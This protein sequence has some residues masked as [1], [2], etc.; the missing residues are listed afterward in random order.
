MN[1]IPHEP[2]KEQIDG[3][4]FE[5]LQL[6]HHIFQQRRKELKLTQQQVADQARIQLR[7]YQRLESGEQSV[8]GSSSRIFFSV[9]QVLRLEPEY[10]LGLNTMQNVPDFQRKKCVILDPV[11]DDGIYYYIPQSAYF[12]LVCEIP[13][14]MIATYDAIKECLRKAYNLSNGEI[15]N[16]MDS[17]RLHDKKYFPYWRVVSSTGHLM[18]MVYS[19]KESQKEFLSKE[20]LD[21]KEDT[22]TNSYSVVNYKKHLFSFDTLNISVRRSL[23]QILKNMEKIQK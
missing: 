12:Q 14:G 23:K 19:S 13:C 18:D 5:Y 15:K 21:I 3:E 2:P 22:E 8:C 20:H 9:C 10:M 17:F 7:Q 1:Y 4:I 6:P 11:D 16:D